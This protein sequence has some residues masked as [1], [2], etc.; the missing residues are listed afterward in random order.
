MGPAAE[1]FLSP[2]TALEFSGGGSELISST[3][4]DLDN[5]DLIGEKRELLK[6]GNLGLI[7]LILRIHLAHG[8]GRLGDLL[9][10]R[11]GGLVR[12]LP[13]ATRVQD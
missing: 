4:D 1:A 13:K 7:S 12:L 3:N 6:S 9:S 8:L 2:A 11:L 5:V 10:R